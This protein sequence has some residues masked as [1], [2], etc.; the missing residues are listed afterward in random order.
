MMNL[1]WEKE[2]KQSYNLPKQL[3][4]IHTAIFILSK[5]M[6]YHAINQTPTLAKDMTIK[7]FPQ[8]SCKSD[9]SN[10]NASKD[11]ILSYTMKLWKRKFERRLRK[12]IR[13]TYNQFSFMFGSSTTKAVNLLRAMRVMSERSK[14]FALSFH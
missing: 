6:G 3:I 14:T 1:D 12:D 10:L 13:V 5:T 7:N 9:L 2:T 4:A 8:L 11:K